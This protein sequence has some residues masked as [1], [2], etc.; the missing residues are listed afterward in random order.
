MVDDLDRHLPGIAE[1]D[2]VAFA[3]W[4]A[5]VEPQLRRSL[6]SFAAHVDTEAVVQEA[7]LTAWQVAPRVRRDGRDNS[8]LRFTLRAARNRAISE[9][10]RARVDPVE[11]SRLE[12]VAARDA[13]QPAMPDPLLRKLIALCRDKLPRRPAKALAGRLGS[14]GNTPD[15]VLAEQAGMTLNTF[16]QN[17]RRARLA[18]AR[19]L[20]AQGVSL[21]GVAP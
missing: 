20:R 16:L 4:V 8:L 7:L 21:D 13:E 6:R 2:P 19:C 14:H 1:G 3:G 18:M 12:Q 5:G 9:L 17:V 10:R 15:A 11:I